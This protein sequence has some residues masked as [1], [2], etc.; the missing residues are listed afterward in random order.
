MKITYF[1]DTDTA[2]IEFSGGP[3]QETREVSEDVLIDLDA[4]GRL[5]GMTLEHASQTAA[6]KEL[7]FQ[8]VS[9]APAR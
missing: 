1:P 3:P 6:I 8:E 7:S 2:H 5:V 9:P 4:Q